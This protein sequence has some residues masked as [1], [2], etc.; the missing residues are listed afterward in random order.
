MTA[1]EFEAFASAYARMDEITFFLAGPTARAFTAAEAEAWIHTDGTDILREILQGFFDLQSDRERR[2]KGIVNAQGAPHNAVE[3]DHERSLTTLFGDVD[4][5]RFAYRHR[6]APNLHPL[7]AHLNLPEEQFSHGLR[8]LAAVEAARGSFEEAKDAI[9]RSTGQ[10]VGKR[11]VEELAG[12]AAADFDA[13]YSET[14]RPSAESG[15]VLALSVDGKG[16]VMR[17]QA[18]RPATAKAAEESG[19]KL[20]TRLSKGEKANRKR[21]AE[22][23]AVYDATPIP[24]TPEDVLCTNEQTEAPKPAPTAKAKWFTASVV[25]D[26]ATVIAQVFNEAERRDPEHKRTWLA[27]VDGNNH[28]IDRIKAEAEA[29]SVQVHIVIDFI[30]VLEYLW[31]AAWSFFVEGD[32]AAE[33][34]VLEKAMII[35]SGQAGIAAAAIRRKATDLHLEKKKRAGAD[36]CANYLLN[37]RPYLDYP[38]ALQQGWPI[39]TGVIEGACRHLVKDRMDITG[40]R[41]GLQGAEAVLKLRALRQNGDFNTYWS[42]PYPHLGVGRGS[43]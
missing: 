41:W 32:P 7:D 16:I 24:R 42:W 2:C 8:R 31:Q 30:H 9:E 1:A 26:A 13:F 3:K 17:P 18:L 4:V 38:T 20:S 6:G 5:R 40:A 12:C 39:A 28:Q 14:P 37:K 36:T 21:M 19:Q 27:L 29:R 34:W 35:L 43:R 33:A 25:E 15:D 23:G 10:N 22:V 11:Q